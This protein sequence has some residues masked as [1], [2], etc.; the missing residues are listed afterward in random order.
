MYV[1][2]KMNPAET[3]PGMGKGEIKENDGGGEFKYDI[4]EIL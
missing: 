1:N 2:G 3:T 4:F